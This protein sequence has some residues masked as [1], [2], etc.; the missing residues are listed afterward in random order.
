MKE[1]CVLEEKRIAGNQSKRVEVKG[2]CYRQRKRG[3]QRT[4]PLFAKNEEHGSGE[5]SC[6]FFS[7]F[8][9]KL[10]S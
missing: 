3:Y 9:S 1:E 2:R 7:F 8:F 10:F 4:V 5:V 6:S